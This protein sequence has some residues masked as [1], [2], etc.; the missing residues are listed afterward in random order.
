MGRIRKLIAGVLLLSC[1]GCASG[2]YFEKYE[3]TDKD[4]IMYRYKPEAIEFHKKNGWVKTYRMNDHARNYMDRSVAWLYIAL[5]GT[6][7]VDLAFYELADS[8]KDGRISLLEAQIRWDEIDHA[9]ED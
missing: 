5:R 9:S 2:D 1:V 8:D 4:L 3:K 7:A 6:L